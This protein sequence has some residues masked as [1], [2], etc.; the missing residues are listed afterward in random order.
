MYTVRAESEFN[1]KL[2]PTPLLAA[3]AFVILLPQALENQ[4]YRIIFR[5][6]QKNSQKNLQSSSGENEGKG[7]DWNDETPMR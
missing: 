4:D 6:F 2:S 3:L 5:L 7:K 1:P